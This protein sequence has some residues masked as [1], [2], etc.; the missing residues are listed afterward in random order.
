LTLLTFTDFMILYSNTKI[1]R[2]YVIHY[3]CSVDAYSL[4]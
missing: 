4:A 2:Q 3:G 1:M